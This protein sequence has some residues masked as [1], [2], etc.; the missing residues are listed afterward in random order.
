[1]ALRKVPMPQE[2]PPSLSWPPLTMAAALT[3]GRSSAL[4]L[5]LLEYSRL[6]SPAVVAAAA[7][8]PSGSGPIEMTGLLRLLCSDTS[9]TGAA[10]RYCVAVRPGS[11]PA[12]YYCC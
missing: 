12:H 5:R 4:V 9:P 3:R 1:M 2:P 11:D 7:A 6:L 10:A 8:A